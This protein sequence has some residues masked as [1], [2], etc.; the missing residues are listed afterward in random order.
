MI[1]MDTDKW[2][3]GFSIVGMG[4]LQKD[5]TRGLGGK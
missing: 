4:L 1:G 3:P 5:S 2:L